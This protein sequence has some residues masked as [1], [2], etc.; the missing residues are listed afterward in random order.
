MRIPTR[1]LLRGLAPSSHA[2]TR[3]ERTQRAIA[4]VA[5]SIAA[6]ARPAPQVREREA[7]VPR[8]SG[9]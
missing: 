7:D 8:P 4:A 3:R 2:A 5:V 6:G 1:T 9:G